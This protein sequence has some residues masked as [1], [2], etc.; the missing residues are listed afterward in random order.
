MLII[1]YPTEP[2]VT[3][4]LIT[5]VIVKTVVSPTILEDSLIVIDLKGPELKSGVAKTLLN[6]LSVKNPSEVVIK[7]LKLNAG[8]YVDLKLFTPVSLNDKTCP[9]LHLVLVLPHHYE[10]ITV[11]YVAVESSIPDTDTSVIL[12]PVVIKSV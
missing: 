2:V 5:G 3:A 11:A 9:A 12:F 7:Y 8:G 4:L 6:L 10:R 1:N